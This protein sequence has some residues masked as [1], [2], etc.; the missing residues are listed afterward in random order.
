[1]ELQHDAGMVVQL[2][3]EHLHVD[4]RRVADPGWWQNWRPHFELAMYQTTQ[5]RGHRCGSEPSSAVAVRQ[6]GA[7]PYISV[8]LPAGTAYG[9]SLFRILP[10]S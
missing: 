1:M 6:P 4:I 3:L 10:A 5:C 2:L 9:P 7:V 8:P